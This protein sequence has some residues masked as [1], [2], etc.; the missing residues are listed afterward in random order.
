MAD[1]VDLATDSAVD[2]NQVVL[3]G[4]KHVQEVESKHECE[5][6]EDDIPEER[7]KLGNV[8]LCVFCQS[9]LERK[10]KVF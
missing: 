8:T 3:D 4:L 10:T 6:C 1:P 9:A 5:R 2:V 7:R